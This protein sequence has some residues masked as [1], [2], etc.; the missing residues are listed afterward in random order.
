MYRQTVA[1]VIAIWPCRHCYWAGHFVLMIIRKF[2]CF[3]AAILWVWAGRIA[4]FFLVLWIN[5]PVDGRYDPSPFCLIQ[6]SHL[7]Q[8]PSFP[9][10]GCT[11]SQTCQPFL[12][13]FLGPPL[14][15]HQIFGAEYIATWG[16]AKDVCTSNAIELYANLRIF[17]LFFFN[18]F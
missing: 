9:T 10:T 13:P 16:L 1:S 14:S 15:G 2:A 7:C 3:T 11:S 12:R 5:G 4:P 17:F 6:A 8:R 18:E